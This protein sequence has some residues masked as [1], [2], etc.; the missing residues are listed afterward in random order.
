M[1]NNDGNEEINYRK[2]M[3]KGLSEETLAF[4]G[5]DFDEVR[6]REFLM[7]SVGIVLGTELAI[8]VKRASKTKKITELNIIRLAV[9][10][11]LGGD[12]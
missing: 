3:N 4:L 8:Q 2:L 7:D 1:K 6:D 11:Y 10:K 12:E 9:K 5:N